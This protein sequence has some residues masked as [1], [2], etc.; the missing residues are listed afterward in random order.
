MLELRHLRYF[1]AVAE[2]R[3]FSRAAERLHMAQP[4][5]S[6]A[7]RQLEQEVGAELLARSSRGVTTT[8][9]G[10]AFLD[11]ARRILE[12]IDGAIAAARRVAA[13]ELGT[14]QIAF[15]WSA[16]FDTLPALARAF[17]AREPDVTVITREIWNAEVP[18]A[19]RSQSI[20]LAISLCPERAGELVY[21][22]LRREPAVAVLPRRHP[23]AD[24]RELETA[25]LR[26]EDFLLFPRELAPRLHDTMLEICRRGG[27]EPVIGHRSFHSTGDTGM[28]SASAGVSLAPASVAGHLH[29]A[30]AI[31]L[32]DREAVLDTYL[33]WLDETDSPARDRF[34]EIARDVFTAA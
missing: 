32:A 34:R 26:D 13:G 24:R 9:A 22:L 19:L 31:P 16:R 8:P 10:A 4:P 1:I 25:A 5:L 27:F 33:V 2:E 7:I 21:E 3:N 30:V 18:S 28:F 11:R 29:D 20:D 15:S 6:V 23:L 14:L 17:A 12:S